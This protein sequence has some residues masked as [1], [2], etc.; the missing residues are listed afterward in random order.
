MPPHLVLYSTNTF[1]KFRIQSE[2]RKVFFAWCSPFFD[3]K[4]RGGY[5]L[6][7]GQPP[8]SDPCAIYFDLREAVKR[9]DKHNTKINDQRKT[10]PS[11]AVKWNDAG[12]I[13]DDEYE[14]IGMRVSNANFND[15]RPI[16]YV[17][18]A[19]GLGARVKRGK[20]R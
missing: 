7:A 11:V 1:L 19:A 8:S 10:I 17:I 13:T 6:G 20:G 2:Y 12:D 14:E 3:G 18:P 15:W 5:D 9:G 16:I 4:K